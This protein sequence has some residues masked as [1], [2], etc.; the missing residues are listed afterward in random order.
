MSKIYV[1]FRVPVE[2]APRAHKSPIM[3]PASTPFRLLSFDG[4][5]CEVK[6]AGKGN[7]IPFSVSSSLLF[8]YVDSDGYVPFNSITFRQ[9]L[10]V[11]GVKRV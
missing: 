3:Y 1:Y 4:E 2:G 5:A 10:K 8:F 7:H 6:K 11:M 9:M